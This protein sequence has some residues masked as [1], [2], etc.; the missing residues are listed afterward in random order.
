MKRGRA[1]LLERSKMLNGGIAF[2]ASEAVARIDAVEF[3]HHMVA[4]HFGE[5]GSRRD[6]NR[7]SVAMYQRALLDGTES[8]M[9]SINR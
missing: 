5:N 7:A 2:V 1:K 4:G 8:F 6:G 9:A 3:L